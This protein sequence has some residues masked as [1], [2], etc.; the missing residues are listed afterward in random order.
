MERKGLRMERGRRCCVGSIEI[1][2]RY[3]RR[4]WIVPPHQTLDA[5]G[6][7]HPP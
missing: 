6:T 1:S 4:L 3:I 7:G 5:E 2:A